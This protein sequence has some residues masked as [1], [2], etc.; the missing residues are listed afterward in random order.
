[1]SPQ[2]SDG[3]ARARPELGPLPGGHHGLSAEQVSE[4]QRER[5]IAAVVHLVAEHGYRV[6]TITEIVKN[7]SVSTRVFYEL[8][9]SKEDCFL[10]AFEAILDHLEQLIETTVEPIADWPHRVVAALGAALDLFTA[11]PDLARFFLLETVSAS[12][13]IANR[14]REAV[15][16]WVPRLQ[17]GR[18]ENSASEALPASTEDTLLGGALSLARRSI[19]AGDGQSLDALLP[20]LVEFLLAPFLGPDAARKLALEAATADSG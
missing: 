20:D 7:A 12:P 11:E 18:S 15:L 8:F 10:A 6:T 13:A 17:A 2:R 19:L 1:M 5:L 9:S 14:F 3:K 16:A 4:S